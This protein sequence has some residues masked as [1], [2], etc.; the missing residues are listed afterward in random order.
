MTTQ[1]LSIQYL[2]VDWGTTN[3]RVFAMDSNGKIVKQQ[4]LPLGLLQVENGDFAKALQGAL[5]TWLP[6]YEQ[7][8]IYMA[9]MV[10]SQAGWQNVPYVAT[11]TDSTQLSQQAFAFDLPWG[12]KATIIPGVS[13]QQDDHYDVMRGEEVQLVGLA[14]SIGST[15]FEAILPGT[16]SKHATFKAGQLVSFQTYMTGELFS[17]I[18]NHTI[19]GKGLVEQA[20]NEAAFLSGVSAAKNQPLSH[21]LFTARTERLF[22]QL[23][24]AHVFDYLSGLLIG[25]ELQ[26][27]TSD[28]VYLI[29]GESLCLRYQLACKTMNIKATLVSGDGCFIEGMKNLV[30][31]NQ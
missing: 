10:G 13:H 5:A 30:N 19:L 18:S 7:Y 2:I 29:G 11:P 3:F 8:A 15:H 28:Y 12:A 24:D 22:E 9:G 26:N 14:T 21:V 17:V 6:N 4:A 31:V 16:H 20:A 23:D 27:L 25:Y 1:T